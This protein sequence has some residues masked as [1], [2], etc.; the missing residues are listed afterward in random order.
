MWTVGRSDEV[1]LDKDSSGE[2]GQADCGGIITG[3]LV[4]VYDGTTVNRSSQLDIDD[5]V[6]LAET[7]DSGA[8]QWS[9]HRRKTYATYLDDHRHLVAVTASSNRSKG[10][11]DPAE[12][13]PSMQQ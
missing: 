3:E 8:S 6:P 5:F 2:L 11:Q 7:W 9:T 12:W 13:M 10:D 4:S 1:L